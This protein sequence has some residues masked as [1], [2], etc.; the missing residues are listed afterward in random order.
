MGDSNNK[1]EQL[2]KSAYGMIKKTNI[3]E[4]ALRVEA[5]KFALNYL[6]HQEVHK[7]KKN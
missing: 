4:Q 2:L 7:T 6:W 3:T 5:F 1:L